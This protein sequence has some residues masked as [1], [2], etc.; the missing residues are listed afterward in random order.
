MPDIFNSSPNHHLT[1]DLAH[2]FSQNV[3]VEDHYKYLFA[4]NLCFKNTD[5][6]DSLYC[7]FWTGKPETVTQAVAHMT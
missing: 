2:F 5:T 4:T 7:D 6:D 1:E 3:H